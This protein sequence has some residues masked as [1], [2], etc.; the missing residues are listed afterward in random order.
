LC[1][2]DF[3]KIL[4]QSEKTGGRPFACSSNDPFR[5]FINSHGMVDLGFMGNPF[6]WSNN[7]AGNCLIKE[8]LDRGF[9]NTD[10]IKLF[11]SYSIVHLPSYSSDHNPIILDTAVSSVYLPKPFRFEEFWTTHPSCKAIISSAWPLHVTGS[12]SLFYQNP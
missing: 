9:A 12:P 2:G 7:R 5:H 6:T 11:P 10:W 3:N 1:I 4:D 8:R